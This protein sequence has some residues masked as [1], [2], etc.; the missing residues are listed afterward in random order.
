ML[1][2]SLFWGLGVRFASTRLYQKLLSKSP[3]ST[4]KIWSLHIDPHSLSRLCGN[5]HLLNKAYV[6][7]TLHTDLNPIPEVHQKFDYRDGDHFPIFG[8]YHSTFCDGPG[9]WPGSIY[10]PNPAEAEILRQ[11]VARR[12]KMEGGSIYG[13]ISYKA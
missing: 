2:K 8:C 12:L 5:A 1:S 4:T 11:N 6:S 13:K 7:L 9:I 3:I 10:L